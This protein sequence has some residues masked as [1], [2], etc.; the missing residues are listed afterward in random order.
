M[1]TDQYFNMQYLLENIDLWLWDWDDTLIDTRTYYVKEMKPDK[2]LKRTDLELDREVPGWRYFVDLITM[3]V[4]NGKSVGI[5][6]FGTY[7]IIQAYMNRMFESCDNPFS[8]NNI[9]TIKRDKNNYKPLEM[10]KNK[11]DFIHILQNKYQVSPS[12]TILF[13][14][15]ITNVIDSIKDGI[16]AIHLPSR[17]SEYKVNETQ[18]WKDPKRLFNYNTIK[19]SEKY[20]KKQIRMKESLVKSIENFTTKELWKQKIKKK[21]KEEYKESKILCFLILSIIIITIITISLFNK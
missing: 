6:S 12:R 9:L 3:L 2:I 20:I 15:V 18:L 8:K 4:M 16:L 7:S 14:D 17:E 5:V 13:D 19:K 10:K 21:F 1:K 11:N